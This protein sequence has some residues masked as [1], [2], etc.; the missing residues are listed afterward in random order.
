[1]GSNKTG[2][3]L[4]DYLIEL[5]G[6]EPERMKPVL[7]RLLGRLG[8][9]AE[10]LTEDDVRRVLILFLEEINLDLGASIATGPEA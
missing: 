6:V 9:S 1:M 3:A 8:L 2:I 7:D 5:S 4:Y 10:A